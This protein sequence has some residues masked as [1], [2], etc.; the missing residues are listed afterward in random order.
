[1]VGRL[2]GASDAGAAT[3]DRT[4]AAWYGA[5]D[6]AA[7]AWDRASAAAVGIPW[8]LLP[9]VVDPAEVVGHLEPGIAHRAALP[10]GIPVAAGSGDGPA[11]WLAAGPLAQGVCIDTGGTGHHLAIVVGRFQADPT[12]TLGCLPCPVPGLWVLGGYTTS[13][14]LAHRWLADLL[15]G[16]R[17]ARL[18]TAARTVPPGS[19]GLVCIPH[20]HGRAT[21]FAPE[22]RGAYLGFEE[23]TTRGHLYR[24]L[25]EAVALEYRDWVALVERMVPG[26]RLQ[27]VVSVGGS[28]A[29][30]LWA[31]IKAAVL[32]VPCV[33][34]GPALEASR[35]AAMIAAVAIG[36]VSWDDAGWCDRA[37]LAVGRHEPDERAARAYSDVAVRH[38]LVLEALASAFRVL[39]GAPASEVPGDAV[40]PSTAP[41]GRTSHAG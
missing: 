13:T 37:R 24:A 23:R 7:G 20:L 26:F 6:G 30:E 33:R 29:S 2:T 21:P 25:L 15:A 16:G 3:C 5:F 12:G 38:R 10:L 41:G 28:A 9:R 22:V 8:R 36:A 32:G 27:E 34:M 31:E 4:Q 17:Y 1:V 19:D 11:G 40:D 35:G 18:E 39:A 14:G